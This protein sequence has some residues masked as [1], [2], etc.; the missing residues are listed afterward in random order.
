MIKMKYE[1]LNHT[2]DLKVRAYGKSLEEAFINAAVGGF[3][4]LVD[5][6]SIAKKIEKKIRIQSKSK[7]SLLFDFLAELLF[8]VDADGFLFAGAKDLKIKKETRGLVLECTV[9]G[10]N[11]RNY[12]TKGDIKAITYSEMKINEKSGMFVIDVVYDI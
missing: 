4:F 5:T 6:K 9:L 10:D 11:Y 3:D 7:E 8:L 12:V 1:Y 2:A